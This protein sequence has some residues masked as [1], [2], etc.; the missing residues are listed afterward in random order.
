MP[1]NNPAIIAWQRASTL[2]VNVQIYNAAIRHAVFLER[3]KTGESKK[4]IKFLNTGVFPDIVSRIENRIARIKSRGYD[5][6]PTTSKQLTDTYSAIRG[7]LRKGMNDGYVQTSK[8]LNDLATTEAQFQTSLVNSVMPTIFVDNGV[9]F[10]VPSGQLLRSIVQERPFQGQLLKDWFSG[11]AESTQT[12]IEKAVNIG[13]AQGDSIPDLIR[14]VRGT[15]ANQFSD[16]VMNIS[17]REAESIVRTAVS[18]TVTQARELT[19]EENGELIDGVQ[20][21]ATL[22]TRTTPQCQALDGKVFKIGEGPRPPVHFNCRSTTVPVLKSWKSLGFDLEELDKDGPGRASMNGVVPQKTTYPEWLSQQSPEV[23][24]EVLGVTRAKLFRDGQVPI[25]RFVDDRG[26]T[27][28]LTELRQREGLDPAPIRKPR[29]SPT[30]KP[31][32]SPDTQIQAARARADAEESARRLAEQEAAAARAAAAEAERARAAAEEAAS[33]VRDPI[34]ENQ[35]LLDFNA[36]QRNFVTPDEFPMAAR[37]G[38]PLMRGAEWKSLASPDD[39]NEMIEWV[40]AKPLTRFDPDRFIA[41]NAVDEL[42]KIATESRFVLQQDARVHFGTTFNPIKDGKA[43]FDAVRTVALTK[44][45]ALNYANVAGNEESY[46]FSVTLP[47]GTRAV[48]ANVFDLPE[49]QLLPGTKFDV[50]DVKKVIRDGKTVTEVELKIINDGTDRTRTIVDFKSQLKKLHD[51]A[52]KAAALAAE[53]AAKEAAEAAAAKAAKEAAEAAAAKAAKEAAEAAAA[54][55]AKE[56]AEKA[57]REAAAERAAAQARADAEKAARKVAEAEA[58][59]ARQAAEEAARKAAEA[60]ARRVAEEAARQA[61]EAA[62]ERARKETVRI[63]A[64]SAREQAR[65]VA[66]AA[67]RDAA[68]A[69][70]RAAAQS[71]VIQSTE[72][73]GSVAEVGR[74]V[75]TRR[76]LD[77]ELT[78]EQ[79]RRRAARR[80]RATAARERADAV[81]A[82]TAPALVE[83]PVQYNTANLE[84]AVTALIRQYF[85]EHTAEQW[86]GIINDVDGVFDRV[87]ISSSSIFYNGRPRPSLNIYGRARAG[88]EDSTIIRTLFRDD[89]GDIVIYNDLFTL[90]QSLS[91]KGLGFRMFDQQVERAMALGVKK[92]GVTAARNSAMN[93][94][95]TWAVFGYDGDIPDEVLPKMRGTAFEGATRIRH[96]MSSPQGIEFWKQHGTTFSGEFDLTEGSYSRR[97]LDAYRAKKRGS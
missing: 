68:F 43:E 59:A 47:K 84:S 22:D 49:M 3:L 95:Y 18:H 29:P 90:D 50:Q 4:I 19:Y 65:L 21:V 51:D 57:A 62:A 37:G 87:R 73:P 10:S 25:E 20:F 79:A 1:K 38:L 15:A 41:Q 56:A 74:V 91:G 8:S 23:Q 54:K 93:G 27:L 78:P 45:R 85:S 28:T 26:R 14:R 44:D 96:I 61:A 92:F 75:R 46:V 67:A 39:R 71:V 42:E 7:I 33:A 83:R 16:G 63:A 40:S 53:Q 80:E 9:S 12:R 35:A 69:A 32:V 55:A 66:E 58:A 77:S 86:A 72:T 36:S 13:L 97:T 81:D 64:E 2:P 17:R 11:L 76:R 34:A 24:N 88:L 60:E 82:G 89:A 94:Y 5:V 70:E 48:R 31:E 52:Q 30:P 6:G